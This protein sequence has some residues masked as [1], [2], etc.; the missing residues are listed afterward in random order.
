MY[1][2]LLEANPEQESEPESPTSEEFM[3]CSEQLEA[4]N[5]DTEPKLPVVLLHALNGSQWHNIMRILAFIN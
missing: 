4:M 1:Q 3:E 5:Q 2:M